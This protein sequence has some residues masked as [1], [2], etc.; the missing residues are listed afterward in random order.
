MAPDGGL[1]YSILD[2]FTQHPL[3][4]NALAIFTDASALD[5]SWMQRIARGVLQLPA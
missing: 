5:P 1:A 3:E 2:V 4:D